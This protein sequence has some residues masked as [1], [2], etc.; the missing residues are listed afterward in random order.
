MFESNV[1]GFGS[2][3][4][5]YLEFY[6]I[7]QSEFADRIG[8]TQKHVNSIIN[9][10]CDIS[11]DLMIAISLIT[12]IDLNLILGMEEEKKIHNYLKEKFETEKEVNNYLKKFHINEL[13]EKNWLSF[14]DITSPVQNTIDLL[15]Y[16]NIRDF[17][18]LK[19]YNNKKILYKKKDDADEIKVSLW[20]AHCD[21]IA[22][23]QKVEEYKKENI[24]KLL[25]ELES[26]RI[27][28]LNEEK[29]IKLFNKYG[30]Y[31]VIEEALKGSKL[32]GCT[33]VKINNPAIYMTK[34]YKDKASFYFALYH[35]IGHVKSDY[36][37]AKSKVIIDSNENIEKRADNFALNTMIR[38]DIWDKIVKNVDKVESICNDNHI[39]ICFVTSRLAKEG[40][41]KYSSTLY[42]KYKEN[43]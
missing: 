30:I 23:N 11:V 27:E 20:L 22:R 6:K 7:S 12:D 39:P 29:L 36:N 35:E 5:R 34:L 25:K 28:K 40:I 21:K 8:V 15:E 2:M 18:V 4:R 1:Y 33:S 38:T 41:I 31:L 32:R 37:M 42:N 24:N 19:S 43:I 14:K 26:I 16:L 10:K 3:L 17:E 13:Q 9:N